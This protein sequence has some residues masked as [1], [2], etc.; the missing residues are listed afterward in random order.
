MAISL[1]Q[2]ARRSR[3]GKPSSSRPP[4]TML[5]GA[6][7]TLFSR[8]SKPITASALTDLPLPDSP[9]SAT[10]ALRG[11][12]KETPLTASTLLCLSMR[13]LTRNWRTSNRISSLMA[14]SFHF[15]IE[16]IAQ[17]VG[18]QRERR[19]QHRHGDRGGGQLLPFAEYQF[20]LRLVQHAA[21]Q[22]HAD[23]HAEAEEAPYHFGLD[24]A[25]HQYRH[26]H[27]RD[28]A[29]VGEDVRVHAPPVRGADGV[30]RHHVFARLV[31]DV[32]G[33]HQAERAGPAGQAEDQHDGRHAF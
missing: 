22:H 18:E 21:P 11:T 26:L 23:R 15:G 17:R 16:R 32:L 31:L 12:L 28:V 27:Q 9:T 13:K 25:D 7:M 20:V 3:A 19:H 24:E 5:L 29:D 1:P 33:A 10:V 30:G 2:M 8:G 14:A 4:N 6:A